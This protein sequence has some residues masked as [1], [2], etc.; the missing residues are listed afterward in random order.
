MKSTADRI[1]MA[2][3]EIRGMMMRDEDNG[4]AAGT[5]N[6]ILDRYL[7]SASSVL[8]SRPGSPVSDFG[9]DMSIV[10]HRDTRHSDVPYSKFWQS[11]YAR[12]ANRE[13]LVQ[14]ATDNHPPEQN[15]TPTHN[16]LPQDTEDTQISPPGTPEAPELV[17]K[18][19]TLQPGLST[20]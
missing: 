10:V 4:K 6:L 8:S 19:T 17:T 1:E 15:H 7:S 5:Y 11:I 14:P 2:V 13:S 9:L 3:G 12:R 16:H 20:V 18:R